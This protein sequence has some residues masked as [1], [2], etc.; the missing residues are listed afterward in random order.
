MA[1]YL[2]CLKRQRG[3]NQHDC[4]M[5]SKEYLQCRM[6]RYLQPHTDTKD[7]K[8]DRAICRNL[9]A[10]DEMKNLGYAPDQVA[11]DKAASAASAK[12]DAEKK[13]QKEEAEAKRSP[14]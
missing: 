1:S 11:A 14:T 9:M 5:L 10:P 6:D 12:K 8:P 7:L 2:T 4:R 3:V 13:E